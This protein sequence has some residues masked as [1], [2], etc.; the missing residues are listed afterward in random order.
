MAATPDILG[1][2]AAAVMAMVAFLLAG[3]PAEAEPAPR[4][5][6]PSAA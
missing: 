2:V 3:S 1:A 5:S 6:R 4:V